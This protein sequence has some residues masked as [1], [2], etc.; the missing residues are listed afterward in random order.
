[1]PYFIA[2]TKNFNVFSALKG[3]YLSGKHILRGVGVQTGN[4]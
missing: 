4:V 2:I 1:M 3:L